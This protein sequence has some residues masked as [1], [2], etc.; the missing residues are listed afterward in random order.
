MPVGTSSRRKGRRDAD[1]IEDAE[2][3]Q[4]MDQDEPVEEEDE[5][6]RR[7]S[8]KSV[9]KEKLASSK[10]APQ[11]AEDAAVADMDEGGDAGGQEVQDTDPPIDVDNFPDHPIDK[12]ESQKLISLSSDW[13][14]VRDNIH[15]NY[16]SV[17]KD[18]AGA[19]AEMNDEGESQKVFKAVDCP[20][21][22]RS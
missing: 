6:P 17:V 4:R 2:A 10:K 21:L 5:A 22:Y 13:K 7:R 19:A 12:K 16:Y 14:Q 11:A 18:V 3:S 8:A 20:H 15:Q 9:K 1:E